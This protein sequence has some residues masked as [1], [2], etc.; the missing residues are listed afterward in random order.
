[1]SAARGVVAVSLDSLDLS[2]TLTGWDVAFAATV[3]IATWIAGRLARRGVLTVLGRVPSAISEDMRL[4]AGRITKYFVWVIGFGVALSFLGAQVQPLLAAAVLIAAIAALSLR[5]IAENFGCGL[6]LQS[7]KTIQLGDRVETAGHTGTV[8]AI[9]GRAVILETVDGRTVHV[10]NSTVLQQPLINASVQGRRRSDLEVRAAVGV[11]GVDGLYE[12][13]RA[14][15]AVAPAVDHE[16]APSLATVAIEPERVT[17]L[18]RLWHQPG[19]RVTARSDAV[20]AIAGALRD[21][22]IRATV[23]APPPEAP[24]TPSGAL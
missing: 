5:G 8:K 12:A 15:I 3:V 11:D 1:M 16:V 20:H 2:Q 13:V 14:G 23:L 10:P 17:L 21:H 24:Q 4:L 6:L 7:R 19:A 9:N 18:V 22:R